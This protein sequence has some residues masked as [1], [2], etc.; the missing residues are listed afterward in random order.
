LISVYSRV[1]RC[2][3]ERHVIAAREVIVKAKRVKP[4]LTIVNAFLQRRRVIGEFPESREEGGAILE[5]I[6]ALQTSEFR[7]P[8]FQRRRGL[9]S[10]RPRRV[11]DVTEGGV[12]A[13]RE[14]GGLH[15]RYE[16]RVA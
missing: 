6:R 12:I 1:S 7:S 5:R 13:F 11:Q 2:R 4:S 15:H 8:A 9:R 14:V 3:R 10:T 16:R